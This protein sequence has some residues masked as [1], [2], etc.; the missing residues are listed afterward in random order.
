MKRVV[1]QNESSSM[2]RHSNFLPCFGVIQDVLGL[3]EMGKNVATI[4]VFD[5]AL[6]P[7]QPSCIGNRKNAFSKNPES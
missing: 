7:A 3:I 4:Q 2:K 5:P 6:I 1:I